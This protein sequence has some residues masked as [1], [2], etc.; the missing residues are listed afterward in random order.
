MQADDKFILGDIFLRN[1]YTIFSMDDNLIGLVPSL[2]S[3]VSIYTLPDE[4]GVNFWT[5]GLN[6]FTLVGTLNN[7]AVV[8]TTFVSIF[9]IV[10]CC[11]S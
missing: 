4:N 7:V 8:V 1:Y 5:L 9:Y 11:Q 10:K 6:G 2:T 3:K